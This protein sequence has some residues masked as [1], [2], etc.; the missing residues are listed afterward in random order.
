M[1]EKEEEQY[2]AYMTFHSQLITRTALLSGF[3]FSAIVVIL[4]QYPN[5]AQIHAQAGLFALNC[6]LA[7]HLYE[8]SERTNTLVN[9]IRVA[10]KLPPLAAKRARAI[11]T[12]Q[13]YLE[14]GRYGSGCSDTVLSLEPVVSL[15]GFS[16]PIGTNTHRWQPK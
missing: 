4:A 9:C 12:A 14:L 1:S 2:S 13:G 6:A 5:V 8:L 3:L 7:L 16:N 10:P 15:T 11:R